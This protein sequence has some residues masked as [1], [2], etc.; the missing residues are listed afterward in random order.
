MA[1]MDGEGGEEGWGDV[2]EDTRD[3]GAED[4]SNQAVG[5]VEISRHGRWESGKGRC[6]V[7]GKRVLGGTDGLRRVMI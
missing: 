1:F 7:T 4:D 5:Q 2:E 6:A 3:G